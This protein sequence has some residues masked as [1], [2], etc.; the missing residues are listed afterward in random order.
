MAAG[1][2]GLASR[3]RCQVLPPAGSGLIYQEPPTWHLGLLARFGQIAPYR[4]LVGVVQR[5]VFGAVP[6]VAAVLK[7]MVMPGDTRA[8]DCG[9]L[10]IVHVPSSPPI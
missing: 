2:A 4:P 8:L 9:A 6:S 7:L 1:L 10:V 5:A 3:Q